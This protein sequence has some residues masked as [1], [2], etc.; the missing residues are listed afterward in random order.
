MDQFKD[1]QHNA[2]RFL[3]KVAA[4]RPDLV[5]LYRGEVMSADYAE[6]LT[7][8]AFANPDAREYP[9]H[10]VGHAVLSKLYAEKYA[11]AAPVKERIDKALALYGVD[12]AKVSLPRQKVAKQRGNGRFLLPQYQRLPINTPDDVKVAGATLLRDRNRLRVSTLTD[13]AMRLVKTAGAM[14]LE[15]D[16]LPRDVYKY[17]GM[18]QCD[19]SKL[20]RWLDIRSTATADPKG[21]EVFFKMAQEVRT[22]GP[23]DPS[24]KDRD[25]LVKL[26]AIIA[27]EDERFGITPKY[28]R[29]IPDAAQTVFN[30]TKV[31]ET[32]VD[33]GGEELPLRALMKV[34]AQVYQD[35]IGMDVTDAMSSP[36]DFKAMLETL[37]ADLRRRAA[38]HLKPHL[39]RSGK[40]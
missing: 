5:P 22:R 29:T 33:L 18:T 34:D 21:R 15:V 38:R 2:A 16:D 26:A 13:A 1:V 39:K 25:S 24:F 32:M 28:N 9:V 35:L 37:P 17:A 8:H 14:N 19:A 11:A 36:E 6:G 27:H 4:A 30:T 31:A 3:V 20:A 10:T 23:R 12:P 7:K 40:A